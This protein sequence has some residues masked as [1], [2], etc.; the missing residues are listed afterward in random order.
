MIL[1]AGGLAVFALAAAHY[2]SPLSRRLA[3]N[4]DVRLV[5][6]NKDRPM[7]LVYHPSSKTLNAVR[8]PARAARSGS[9]YQRACEVL[10]LFP[11]AIGQA[12][13]AYIEVAAS[14]GPDMNAFEGLVNTWRARPAQ[15]A[16]GAEPAGE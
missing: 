13:P 11:G 12:E 3:A 14:G 7:M 16:G 8:L 4:E 15:L 2:L 10:K 6:L 5:L 1:A 9:A